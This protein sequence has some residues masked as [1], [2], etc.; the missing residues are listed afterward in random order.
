[1]PTTYQNQY[2]Y[3]P[4]AEFKDMKNLESTNK[5]GLSY[6]K[7]ENPNDASRNL[8][9]V[10][11]QGLRSGNIEQ[12]GGEQ[13]QASLGESIIGLG[14]GGAADTRI[15]IG[16]LLQGKTAASKF[17]GMGGANYEEIAKAGAST[18]ASAMSWLQASKAQ[19]LEDRKNAFD[20]FI[21]KQQEQDQS[22]QQSVENDLN[23]QTQAIGDKATSEQQSWDKQL[24]ALNNRNSMIQTLRQQMEAHNG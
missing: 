18:L 12:N 17:G 10:V 13:K 3:N 4:S 5:Y 23:T 19:S 15:G 2:G 14:S 6:E 21:K 11:S 20:A 1:M 24:L 9:S 8:A 22:R 16:G 7:V